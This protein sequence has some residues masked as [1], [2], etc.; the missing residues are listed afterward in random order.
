MEMK[1]IL[2]AIKNSDLPDYNYVSVI[3]YAL[4]KIKFEKDFER[5]FKSAIIVF[6]T[7]YM[8]EKYKDLINDENLYSRSN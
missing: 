5:V 4:E 7:D 1:D 6:L 2:N 3:L 8:S